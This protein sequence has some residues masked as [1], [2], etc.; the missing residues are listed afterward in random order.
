VG[1]SL[2]DCFN[3]LLIGAGT[4]PCWGSGESEDQQTSERFFHF[5]DAPFVL[6]YWFAIVGGAEK[7]LNAERINRGSLLKAFFVRRL[8]GAVIR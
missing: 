8:K 1:D 2:P 4:S 3:G 6:R 5:D 7:K